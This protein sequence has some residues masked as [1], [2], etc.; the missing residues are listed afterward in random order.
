MVNGGSGA[1]TVECRL[2][3]DRQQPCYNCYSRSLT[4]VYAQP[5]AGPNLQPAIIAKSNIQ[6][7]LD[8]LERLVKA[9]M[10]DSNNQRASGPEPQET[11]HEN[12]ALTAEATKSDHL[13][14]GSI[15]PSASEL[16]YVEGDHWASILD[17]IADL[18]IRVDGHVTSNYMEGHGV[19]SKY[20]SPHALLLYGCPQATSRDEILAGLP[21]KNVV[22]R[23]VSVY[24]NR[25][26]IAY[27]K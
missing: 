14:H 20:K 3:C 17:D 2:R 22:D 27:C 24:F 8:H 1:L 4:C 25:L 5:N 10:P 12:E 16:P 7:R 23:H 21:P 26:D 13:E 6:D 18:K 15:H 19:M 9:I 11:Q